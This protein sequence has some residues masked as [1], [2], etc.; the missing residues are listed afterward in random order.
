MIRVWRQDTTDSVKQQIFNKIGSGI[1]EMLK[2]NLKESLPTQGAR[3]VA[4]TLMSKKVGKNLYVSPN[5]RMYRRAPLNGKE[6]SKGI[7][8]H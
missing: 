2:G 7:T 1:R 5:G 8:R 4:T 3:D 6:A